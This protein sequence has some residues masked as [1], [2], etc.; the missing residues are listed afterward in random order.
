MNKRK[1]NQMQTGM[2]FSQFKQ[3]CLMTL[4][5]EHIRKKNQISPSPYTLTK[6]QKKRL[7]QNQKVLISAYLEK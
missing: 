7:S 3:S 5:P 6:I 2:I 1:N 4:N